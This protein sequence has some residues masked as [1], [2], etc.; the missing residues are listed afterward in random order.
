MYHDPVRGGGVEGRRGGGEKGGRKDKALVGEVNSCTSDLT[1][2]WLNH[3]CTNLENTCQYEMCTHVC[4]WCVHVHMC[5]HN[6]CCYFWPLHHL[7][8][9]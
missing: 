2:Q 3:L 5:I 1:T 6:Q 8:H 7:S 4:A 9:A